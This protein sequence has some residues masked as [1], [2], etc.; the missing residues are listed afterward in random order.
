LSA[1]DKT[2]DSNGPSPKIT[3]A[4]LTHDFGD[5]SPNKPYKADI[6]FTNTG[7]GTLEI[8]KVSKC[9]GVVTKLAGGRKKR[10]PSEGGAPLTVTEY[11]P[12]ESGAVLIEWRSGSAPGPFA[13]EFIV[14]SNDTANPAAK[15][16]VKAKVTLKVTWVPKRMRLLLDEDNVGG[17][18]I[19]IKSVDGRPFSITS[20]KSTGDCITADFDPSVE[21]TKFVLEPKVNASKLHQNLKGRILIGLTHPDGNAAIILFDVTPRYTMDPPLLLFF[22]AEPDKPD[23]RKISVLNNYKQD[24][25]VESLSS[26]TG[27]V[28]VRVLSTRKLTHGYQ[29]EFEVTPPKPASKGQIKVLDEFVLTLEDGEKIPIKC[30]LYYTK[31]AKPATTPKI[32]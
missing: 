25:G 2:P 13:R 7:E 18:D 24:F 30:N 9:C 20:F 28:G 23:V 16:K 21:A 8:S 12:G 29:L 10:I 3:F 6:K 27:T 15:L 14:H 31:K 32:K 19:T 26:K 22:Y 17:Q 5:V 1:S 11:G 4:K